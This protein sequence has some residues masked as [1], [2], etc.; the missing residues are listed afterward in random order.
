MYLDQPPLKICFPCPIVKLPFERPYFRSKK[1]NFIVGVFF[2]H[3][4]FLKERKPSMRY[5]QAAKQ[6][7]VRK[8]GQNER[9]SIKGAI[10]DSRRNAH[11]ELH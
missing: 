1:I 4:Q 2:G 8:E 5:N 7:H 9:T 6:N 3:R 11:P 10:A